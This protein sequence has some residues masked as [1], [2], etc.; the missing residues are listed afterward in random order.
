[1]LPA[2]IGPVGREFVYVPVI[3]PNQKDPL[4]GR[5]QF[6][7][8]CTGSVGPHQ[9]SRRT[10][11]LLPGVRQPPANSHG[12]AGNQEEKEGPGGESYDSL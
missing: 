10:G 4:F 12:D 8:T 3:S 5:F 11:D 6:K 7:G 2:L 1:M 9:G